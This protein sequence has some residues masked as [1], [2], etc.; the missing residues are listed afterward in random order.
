[1]KNTLKDEFLHQYRSFLN[2]VDI[3]CDDI[4]ERNQNEINCSPG[5][6]G[7]CQGNLTVNAV[8]A[9]NMTSTLKKDFAPPLQS[10]DT[11]IFLSE[12]QCIIYA[13]RPL[14]C[15]SQGMP[16]LYGLGDEGGEVE[17]SLCQMN[18]QNTEE[19]T[20]EDCLDMDRIN[21]AL[22]ALN[23]KFISDMKLPEDIREKRYRFEEIAEGIILP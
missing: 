8:E 9:Y 14:V 2:Q 6:S 18:F 16:L 19:I 22:A 13:S 4:I 1:M 21:L 10:G 7:C 17:L 3:I 12:G 20:E 5:C 15:R 23:Y 11:C